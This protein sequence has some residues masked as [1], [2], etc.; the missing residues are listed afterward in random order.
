MGYLLILLFLLIGCD[1]TVDPRIVVI[2]GIRYCREA[3]EKLQDLDKKNGNEDCKPYYEDIIVDGRVM[4]CLNFCRYE[5][6][7]SVD[8]HPKC[9][10]DNVESC[11]P[12][13]LEK[14]G[15]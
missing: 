15:L 9:I 2:P 5:M 4:T 6:S 14:C 10:L 3:C 8:L 12:D 13:M 1:K 11:V 7:N